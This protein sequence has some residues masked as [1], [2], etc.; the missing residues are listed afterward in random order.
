M[1]SKFSGSR[2]IF[3]R[4]WEYGIKPGGAAGADVIHPSPVRPQHF[5]FFLKNVLR[6]V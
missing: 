6:A 4:I 2:N 5:S 1:R 3:L